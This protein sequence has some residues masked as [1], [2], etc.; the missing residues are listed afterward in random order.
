LAFSVLCVLIRRVAQRRHYFA[1][2]LRARKPVFI[3]ANKQTAV[4][5]VETPSRN[6]QPGSKETLAE[7]PR[8]IK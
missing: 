5:I 6:P 8:K 2:S 1:P 4:P 7:I 3:A